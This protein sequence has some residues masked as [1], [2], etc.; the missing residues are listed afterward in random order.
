M[1]GNLVCTTL[2]LLALFCKAPESNAHYKKALDSTADA[3]RLTGAA[4]QEALKRFYDFYARFAP[5][6]IEKRF[7][8][9]YTE[10]IYFR[11]PYREVRGIKETKAYFLRTTKAIE[12]CTFTIERPAI[13]EG[14]NY[15]FR[16]TMHLTLKRN[17]NQRI[18]IP[19]MSHVR[20]NQDG[21][22]SFHQDYWD[23]SLV[24]EQF[25]LMGPVIR[26]IRASL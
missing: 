23:S 18:E 5:D 4:E 8:E 25:P 1:K 19:G 26:K 14:G 17:K 9:V 22:I 13:R 10:G 6:V 12:E 16:W 15:Y 2:L 24:L 7:E 20:Y 3:V 11:D 21:K